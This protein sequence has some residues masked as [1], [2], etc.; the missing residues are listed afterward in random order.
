MTIQWLSLIPKQRTRNN[1][2]QLLYR[3]GYLYNIG[4]WKKFVALFGRLFNII[5][6][7]GVI[8]QLN[9]SGEP[10]QT[11]SNGN[12]NSFS[13]NSQNMLSQKYLIKLCFYLYFLFK[14]NLFYNFV[15]FLIYSSYLKSSG[16]LQTW[17]HD[18][19]NTQ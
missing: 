6:R 10:I 13:E 14:A 4:Q 16:R 1:K 11:V 8:R 12:V 3:K 18:S 7:T 9:N 17:Q 5:P 2:N 15:M 19:C